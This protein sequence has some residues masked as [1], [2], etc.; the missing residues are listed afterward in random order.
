MQAWLGEAHVGVL[1]E[2]LDMEV[3]IVE[4]LVVPM[5]LGLDW[6]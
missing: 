4:H 2:V 5:V 1:G 3:A 6:I